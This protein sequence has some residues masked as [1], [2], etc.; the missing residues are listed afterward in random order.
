MITS[1][2]LDRW[3]EED[4][5]AWLQAC[6]PG[7]RRSCRG[8][9]SHLKP[10]SQDDLK[11]RYG[12]FL[13]AL[14]ER[15]VLDPNARAGQLV[16]PQNVACYLERVRPGWSSVT[17]AGSVWKLRRVAVILA[18]ASD[19]GWLSEIATDLDLVAY[20]K[21]RFDRIISS[22]VL[23]RAGLTLV[24]EAQLARRRRPI[25]RAGQIRDGLMIAMLAY[26]PI[27]LRTFSELELGRSFVREG[28]RWVIKLSGQQVKTGRPDLRLVRARLNAAIALYLTWARPRLQRRYDEAVIGGEEPS[29]HLTGPL[30]VGQYGEALGYSSVEK[31]IVETTRATIGTAL[32]PHDFRRCGAFT[33]RYRAG[34]EPYLASGLLQHRDQ[35]I[36]DE[37][38]NLASSLEAGL[39]FGDWIE[40]LA[41]D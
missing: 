35:R 31:R 9:L 1:L 29:P 12:Y 14:R 24:K 28:D 32:S 26:H 39:T 4:R 33:A 3:P 7:R 38:Y 10:I 11:R 40:E 13:E 36:V 30:W 34:S 16:T 19:F 37:H 2:P 18:P 8:A 6:E 41:K 27:R 23:V 21:E 22:E 5:L 15:G 17:L 20:R 25:W